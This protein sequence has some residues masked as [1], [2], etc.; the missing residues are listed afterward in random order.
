MSR[1]CGPTATARHRSPRRAAWPS[2]LASGSSAQIS[3]TEAR[4]C[5]SEPTTY[6]R[7]SAITKAPHRSGESHDTL[8]HRWMPRDGSDKSEDNVAEHASFAI[9]DNGFPKFTF[10]HLPERNPD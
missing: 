7:Y 5:P 9:P 10:V 4:K 6:A 1:S 3:S 2:P 8:S